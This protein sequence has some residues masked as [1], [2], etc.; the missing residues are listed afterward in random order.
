M[1]DQLELL[2]QEILEGKVQGLNYLQQQRQLDRRKILTE[3]L[4]EFRTEFIIRSEL[5]RKRLII[6]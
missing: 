5:Q 3:V 4:T 1:N 2:M 6:N